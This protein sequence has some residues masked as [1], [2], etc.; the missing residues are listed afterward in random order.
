MENAGVPN[1]IS[2]HTPLAG[3]DAE[4]RDGP[5]E[6]SISIHTPLAGSDLLGAH[7]DRIVQPISIHTPLAGSDTC[8]PLSLKVVSIF[9][10][11]LPLRGATVLSAP[12]VRRLLFQ[13]T[14]PLRGATELAG[15]E[16]LLNVLIS[17]HTPLAGSD[18]FPAGLRKRRS[19]SIHTPLAG[20]DAVRADGPPL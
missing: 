9:Q 8:T 3:S 15:R 4:V 12:E 2:I 6:P 16:E 17:I 10:S 18:P 20:S 7:V 11:T 1:A 19:I 14:L 5:S 13:S